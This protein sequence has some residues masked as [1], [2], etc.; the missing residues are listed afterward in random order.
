MYKITKGLLGYLCGE[1][2]LDA[3]H[4]D[5]PVEAEVRAF[6]G[7]KMADGKLDLKKFGELTKEE[8]PAARVRELVSA[9]VTKALSGFQADF[10]KQLGDRLGA[11]HDDA[12]TV[13]PAAGAENDAPP[14]ATKAASGVAAK[15]MGAAGLA[16]AGDADGGDG[17]ANVRVKSILEQFDATTR[18]LTYQDS[19]NPMVRKS[20]GSRPVMSGEGGE[21]AARTLNVPSE[22]QK[23][24]AGAWMKR[25][26]SQAFRNG[27]RA[28]PP[29][30]RM[31]ELDTKLCEAAVHESKF[32]GPHGMNRED[33]D[34]AKAWFKAERIPDMWK[35]AVLDDSTSGGLEAVPIEFDDMAIMS[36]VLEG[37]LYPLVSTRTVTRRR[38]EGFSVGEVTVTWT[39][40]GTSIGLFSTAS[41]IS[42]FDTNVYAVTGAM[43][44]GLDFEADSPVAI[45]DMILTRYGQAFRKELDTVIIDGDGTSQP[46]GILQ[47]S[48]TTTVSSDGGSGGPPVV[49][50]YE[51]LLF[52]VA[53][54]YR[55]E[56][57]KA[58]AV[59]I[60]NETSYQRNKAIQVGTTDQR[61]VFG[62]DHEDYMTLGHPHKITERCTNSEQVFCCMNRYRMYRRAGFAVRVVTE[63]QDL[64][65]KNQQMI[66]MRARF[67]G[68]LELGGAAAKI[69]DAQ[70]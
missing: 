4:L 29:S 68:Q 61:R 46:K 21:I 15:A 55:A 65:L 36:P 8:D 2:G 64:A 66:V 9:E 19:G 51:G 53:K 70:S 27:G 54:Q 30:W 67:G 24:I 35:K 11:K 34:M 41:F 42:A 26:V 38:I 17:A 23:A 58:R 59:F 5:A 49:S 52:G 14:V 16:G 20:F 40:E 12:S 13:A 45:G 18:A 48:G 47:A 7:A 62:M 69:T 25:M 63:D 6:I 37:E 3:K 50:D 1:L 33:D 22:R 31:T 43:E 56:A 39:A 57:G 60:T 10:M 32:I 44:I 28:V